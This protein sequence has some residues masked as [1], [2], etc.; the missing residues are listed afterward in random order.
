MSNQG[1]QRNLEFM[2]ASE[3]PVLEDTPVVTEG[4]VDARRDTDS[5]STTVDHVIVPLDGSPLAERALVVASDVASALGAELLLLGIA[6]QSRA[7]EL[8]AYLTELGVRSQIGPMASHVEVGSDAAAVIVSAARSDRSLVCMSSHGHSRFTSTLLGSVSTAV[9]TSI[10]RPVIMLGPKATIGSPGA[11]ALAYLD[12][13]EIPHH[14]LRTA[15]AWAEAFGVSL[16]AVTVAEPVPPSTKPGQASYSRMF[17]PALDADRYLTDIAAMCAH[18]GPAI[19]TQAIFDPISP[20]EGLAGYL[21]THPARFIMVVSPP[22][23]SASHPHIGR[24]V[25][26]IVRSCPVPVLFPE[27]NA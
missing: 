23:S 8:R 20:A 14:A 15:N 2:N 3:S 25:A 21:A 5:L 19:A 7:V 16:T 6:P 9:L 10:D 11:P 17:G 1:L 27:P 13:S 18:S 22:G 26:D 24:G 12:G 4:A